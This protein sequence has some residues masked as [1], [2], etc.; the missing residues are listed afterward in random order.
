MNWSCFLF[1]QSVWSWV[2]VSVIVHAQICYSLTLFLSLL[3]PTYISFHLHNFVYC[4]LVSWRTDWL[5]DGLCGFV[6]EY[7]VWFELAGSFFL[8]FIQKFKINEEQ[9]RASER[10]REGDRP[11]YL[12][13]FCDKTAFNLYEYQQ[14]SINALTH[15]LFHCVLNELENREPIDTFQIDLSINTNTLRLSLIL[16]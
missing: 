13:F 15:V 14:V 3:F 9:K 5:A 10:E 4:W 8:L 7:T 12:T 16:L 6:I 1:N 11:Q 2:F